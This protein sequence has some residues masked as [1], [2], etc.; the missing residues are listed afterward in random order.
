MLNAHTHMVFLLR[1][2]KLHCKVK[3]LETVMLG[4]HKNKRS[5]NTKWTLGI[6]QGLCQLDHLHCFSNVVLTVCACCIGSSFDDS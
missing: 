2:S 3:R 5:G 1:P 6:P 4:W